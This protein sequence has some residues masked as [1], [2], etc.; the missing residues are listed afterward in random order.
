MRTKSPATTPD[1]LLSALFFLQFD[2]QPKG[3]GLLAIGTSEH[4][5]RR[6]SSTAKRQDN[7]DTHSDALNEPLV[8]QPVTADFLGLLLDELDQAEKHHDDTDP[9]DSQDQPFARLL[10]TGSNPRPGI[11]DYFFFSVFHKNTFVQ[12]TIRL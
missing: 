1:R 2:Q 11:G 6:E 7:E 5:N 3:L 9:H 12:Q 8:Q 10:V 4:P